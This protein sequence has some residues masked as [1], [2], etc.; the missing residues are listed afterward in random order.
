MSNGYSNSTI[1]KIIEKSHVSNNV[2]GNNKSTAV[3]S[4]NRVQYCSAPYIP[5]TSER[6]ARIFKQSNI[7]LC[8]KPCNTIQ[9]KVCKLKDRRTTVEQS[10]VVYSLKCEDCPAAYIGEAGRQLGQRITEHRK[11][12][13]R[14]CQLS[15]LNQH[16]RSTSHQF[17]FTDV[18]ILAKET[19]HSNILYLEAYHSL[20]QPDSINRKIDI[21]YQIKSVI[22]Q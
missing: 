20:K 13:D 5:G 15:K 17:S 9:S 2:T 14:N 16:I 11:A 21:C 18:K 6:V 10:N 12:I 22:L 8:H 4:G 19:N 1:L 7:K 3:N